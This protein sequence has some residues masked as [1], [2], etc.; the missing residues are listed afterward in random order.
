MGCPILSYARDEVQ[1]RIIAQLAA[2]GMVRRLTYPQT[3]NGACT[4]RTVGEL[5][6]SFEDRVNMSRLGQEYVDGRGAER[7]LQAIMDFGAPVDVKMQLVN[8]AE[9]GSF[10]GMAERHFRGLNSNFVPHADWKQ[11]YFENILSNPQLS[12]R[13]IVAD[14]NR[15][16]FI[17]FGFEAHRFLPRSNGMIYELYVEPEFRRKGIAKIVARNAV[18]EMKERSPAKIQLAVMKGN[19][20]AVAL[21]ESL[22]FRKVSD[23]FTLSEAGE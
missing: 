10:L 3:G 6:N 20:A 14:E 8:A 15:A 12:L 18:K 23:R 4:A 7:V 1:A 21:W 16:G 9:R 13:W 22:G 19:E 17:L 11:F 2:D 5:A